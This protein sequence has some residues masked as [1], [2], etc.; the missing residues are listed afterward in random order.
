MDTDNRPQPR[1]RRRAVPPPD[2]G[3]DPIAPST[4][5]PPSTSAESPAAATTRRPASRLPI[6]VPRRRRGEPVVQLNVRI[7]HEL[8]QLLTRINDETGVPKSEIVEA[9]LRY[10]YERQEA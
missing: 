5:S 2:E 8:G 10:A 6:D 9:A 7:P 3:R 1:R 4:D